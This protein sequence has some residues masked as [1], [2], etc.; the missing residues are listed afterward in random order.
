MKKEQN[1]QIPAQEGRVYGIYFPVATQQAYFTR[2]HSCDAI[3]YDRFLT[4]ILR[5]FVLAVQLWAGMLKQK[6]R[7]LTTNV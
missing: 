5:I 4:V 3:L 7:Q 6:K 2:Q 1:P